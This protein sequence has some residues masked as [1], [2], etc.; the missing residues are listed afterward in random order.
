MRQIAYS[1][2]KYVRYQPYGFGTYLARVRRKGAGVKAFTFYILSALLINARAFLTS[3]TLK[4]RNAR[5]NT[6][7]II[8]N[9]ITSFYTRALKDYINIALSI[10][11]INHSS[12]LLTASPR[13]L[14]EHVAATSYAFLACAK[15]YGHDFVSHHG[16]TR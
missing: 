13:I 11:L 12:V 9:F 3:V 10:C 5:D 7:G 16:I 6:E 14:R 8:T 15:A 4:G 2:I 1:L